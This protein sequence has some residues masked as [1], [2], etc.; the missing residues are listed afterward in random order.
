MITEFV[1]FGIAF[2]AS[3][4]MFFLS[5]I[6]DI[7][8]LGIIAALLMVPFGIAVVCAFIWQLFNR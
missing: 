2:I 7:A 5:W 3:V 1:Y 4:A 6:T 8:F